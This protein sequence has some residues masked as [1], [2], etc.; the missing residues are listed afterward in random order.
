MIIDKLKFNI[1]IQFEL[2]FRINL[3]ELIN[4]NNIYNLNFEFCINSTH[5]HTHQCN[6]QIHNI[7]FK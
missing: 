6:L 4:F 3:Q 7:N 1:Y 2:I 5:T